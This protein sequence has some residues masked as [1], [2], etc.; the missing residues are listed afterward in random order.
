[1]ITNHLAPAR[2]ARALA[3]L[4]ALLCALAAPAA[5]QTPGSTVI[6]NQASATYSDGT[7]SYSASSNTVT[8][9][10]ANVS[11]LRITPDA[12]AVSAVVPGQTGVDFVFTVTN[13]GNIS[14]QVRFLANGNSVTLSGP[15]TV[16]AAVVDNGDNTV[17]AGD[18]DILTNGADV[19]HALAQNASATVIVRVSVSASAA[20]GQTVQVFLGDAA[21]GSGFDNQAAD[22]S[23]HEVRTVASPTANGLR[24]AR[25][26]IGAAVQNDVQLRT[27]MSVPAGPVALGSDITYGLQACNDG[28]RPAAAATLGGTTGIYVVVPV[29]VGTQLSAANSFP[30]GTLFTTDPLTTDPQSATW[31]TT[32]PGASAR[33]VAFNAG[34]SLAA[35]G[36]CSAT[37]NLLVTVTT[38]DA[39]SPVWA[40]ADGFARNSVSATLNDQSGDSAV[41]QGDANANFNEPRQ[42]LEAPNSTQGLQRPT[43]LQ[44]LGGVLV[45]PLNQPAATGPTN[46]NDDYTNRSVNT[47]IAGVAPGG[48]TTAAGTVVFTN[49]VRNTGNANDT[50]TLTA[51]TVPA[52]FTVEIS[53]NG[54][55]AYTTLSGGGSATLAVAFNAQADILVRVTAPAGR[56]V[57]TPFETVI[58]A[59][60]GVTPASYNETIDRLYTSFLR[61]DKSVTVTNATGMGGPTDAVPGAVIEYVITY[62]NVMST[63]GT[64]CSTLAAA[65]VVITEDGATNAPNNWAAYTD[66]VV[67]SASDSRG[68]T[69]TGD[70][71]VTSTAL[72]DTVA[73]VPAGQSGT[74]RFKRVIK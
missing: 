34:A 56:T 25:G 22:S 38:S 71:A 48:S 62:T 26:D 65:N 63:G 15:G 6:S 14:D 60:S 57:L 43:L 36:A 24:E 27:V 1:M 3:A 2:A 45:G 67:G 32:N 19:L 40:V 11:G 70:G 47:G 23:V 59:T 55:G 61:L 66:H 5:A 68:G 33:R 13:I 21:A 37:F 9:T 10:V 58:R 51:P 17:G 41:N 46:S 8:V 54:G 74:F 44:Q 28:N 69:I 16:A 53:T 4:A 7:N 64:N 20:A 42:G 52:G 29:P 12:G 50:F 30:A 31:S 39:S 35:G 73:S 18:T 72:T 49:T